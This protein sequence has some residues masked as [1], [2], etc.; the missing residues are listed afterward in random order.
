MY[1][2]IDQQCVFH[3]LLPF[4][5]VRQ[6]LWGLWRNFCPLKTKLITPR[7]HGKLIFV[8]QD[9][10]EDGIKFVKRD[11]SACS[12]HSHVDSD[13]PACCI[14]APECSCMSTPHHLI[15]GFHRSH[16]RSV[17]RITLSLFVKNVTDFFCITTYLKTS[18]VRAHLSAFFP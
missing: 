10:F 13:A 12:C 14:L 4:R 15:S 7:S 1:V 18:L 16:N 8:L 6:N 5:V 17:G 11:Y 2:V 3:A 9:V